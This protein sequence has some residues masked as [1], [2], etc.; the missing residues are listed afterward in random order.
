MKK[1]L[2]H[3]TVCI[4]I[5]LLMICGT[6][7][8][9]KIEEIINSITGKGEEKEEGADKQGDS[10]KAKSSTSNTETVLFTVNGQPVTMGEW[11]LYELPKYEEN[12]KLYGNEIWD[13]TVNA[14][15]KK[16]SEAFLEDIRD[17][18]SYIKIVASQAEARGVGLTED[19]DIEI[20]IETADYMSRLTK[21][22]QRKYEITEEDVRQVYRDNLLALKVYE[23]LTLNISTDTDEK[24]VRH[25]VLQYIMIPKTYENKAGETEYYSETELEQFRLRLKNLREAVLKNP[26]MTLKE[27][28]TQDLTATEMVADYAM[29]CEQLPEDL[30]GIAFWLR[31]GE[32]S[33]IYETEDAIFLF[34]CAKK[35]DQE[36]TDEAKV[37]VLEAREKAVFDEAYTKWRAAATIDINQENWNK[38]KEKELKK[39]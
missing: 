39:Q 12:M 22:D 4:L 15:G 25:M 18:I 13:Y 6:V 5:C 29:L 9:S 2:L 11:N 19:D 28:Q 23:N 17:E 7:S 34:N 21:M 38:L 30:A 16:F 31:E 8:C 27:A 33:E 36:S 20:N 14:E 32:V 3:G 35:T 26:Q 24:E 37:R 10:D 1:K